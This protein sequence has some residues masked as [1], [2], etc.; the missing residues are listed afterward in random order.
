MKCIQG[1]ELDAET[2]Y[3]HHLDDGGQP[4]D[5]VDRRKHKSQSKIHPRLNYPMYWN[6]HKGF[7]FDDRRKY[8]AKEVYTNNPTAFAYDER[9]DA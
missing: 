6:E 8:V 9:R 7:W 4:C 1:Y 3:M 5:C 2:G